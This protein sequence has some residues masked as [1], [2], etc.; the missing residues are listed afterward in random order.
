MNLGGM[1]GRLVLKKVF[2]HTLSGLSGQ[3]QANWWQPQK[4][5]LAGLA[6]EKLFD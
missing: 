1:T 2:E 6:R 4:T 5:S 3:P